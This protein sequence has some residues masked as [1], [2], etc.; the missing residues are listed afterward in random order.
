M[1]VPNLYL[2]L[3]LIIF[4]ITKQN[5]NPMANRLL[6]I[7][8]SVA[9]NIDDDLQGFTPLKNFCTKNQIK[10]SYIFVPIIVL[11]IILTLLGLCEHVFATVF[12]MLYPAYMSFKV[13]TYLILGNQQ[14]LRR[15]IETMAYLLD[16][17]RYFYII[18]QNFVYCVVLFTSIL[19]I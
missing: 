2:L 19:Y 13:N 6:E 4:K 3:T 10:P 1:I 7:F 8:T 18:R 16:Y 15:I 17:F 14:E 11:S 9:H 12:G 5:N